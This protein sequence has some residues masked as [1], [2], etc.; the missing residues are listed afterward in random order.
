MPYI[1]EDIN[2]DEP[3]VNNIH[4]IEWIDRNKKYNKISNRDIIEELFKI[5]QNKNSSIKPNIPYGMDN[6]YIYTYRNEL[7]GLAYKFDII[8]FDNKYWLLLDNGKVN[9]LPMDFMNE[10]KQTS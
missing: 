8:T 4:Y 6:E 7:E 5:F 9:E 1:A 3:S 2:L 10:L